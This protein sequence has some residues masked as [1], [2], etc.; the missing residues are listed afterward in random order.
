[1]SHRSESCRSHRSRSQQGQEQRRQLAQLQH[2]PV[3]LTTSFVVTC[4]RTHKFLT[5]ARV[6]R[7]HGRN[8]K[9]AS[10][11]NLFLRMREH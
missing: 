5:S 7:N 1:M 9:R 6:R 8:T 11:P 2:L 3:A 10:Q 4:A